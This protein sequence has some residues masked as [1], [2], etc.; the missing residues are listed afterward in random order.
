MSEL[1]RSWFRNERPLPLNSDGKIDFSLGIKRETDEKVRNFDPKVAERFMGRMFDFVVMPNGDRIIVLYRWDD[2]D[3]DLP[4]QVEN[5]NVFRIDCNGNIIWQV[6]RDEEEFVSWAMR[7][8]Q[9]KTDDP[10]SEGYRD[11]FRNL[12][13]NFFERT[14]MP[15]K[16]V[17]HEKFKTVYFN[18]YA[19]GRLLS[20]STRWWGYDLDPQT[21]VAKCTGEQIK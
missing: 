19:P 9:A 8:Q 15:D 16:G 7:N 2:S 18:Q 4:L 3:P 1:K 12:S 14:P 20:I 17:F 21:G 5:H 11:P 6:R 10:T 13:E